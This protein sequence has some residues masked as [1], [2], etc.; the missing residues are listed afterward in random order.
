MDTFKTKAFCR[1][2]SETEYCETSRFLGW[3][4]ANGFTKILESPQIDQK[5]Y[6]KFFINTFVSKRSEAKTKIKKDIFNRILN[7]AFGK[8]CKSLRNRSRCEMCPNEIARIIADLN[9]KSFT[10]MDYNMSYY[11]EKKKCEF[12]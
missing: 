11:I 7:L 8:I 10:I 12:K 5:P 2:S 1:T 4:L 6:M 9:F 3:M